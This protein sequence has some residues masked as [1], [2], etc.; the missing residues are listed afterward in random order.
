[1]PPIGPAIR[2]SSPAAPSMCMTGAISA[3]RPSCWRSCTSAHRERRSRMRTS[4]RGP[5]NN[6]FDASA[7]LEIDYAPH[8]LTVQQVAVRLVDVIEA[9]AP[10]D[11]LVELELPCLIQPGEPGDVRSGVARAEH[12]TRQRLVHQDEILQIDLD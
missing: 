6:P 1:M 12:R 5:V 11:H 9:I 2:S 10:G 4:R 8:D 7:E 3:R